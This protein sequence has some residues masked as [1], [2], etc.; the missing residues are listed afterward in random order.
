VEELV[1]AVGETGEVLGAGGR[2]G[3]GHSQAS[4]T[5]LS[6]CW[7]LRFSVPRTSHHTRSIETVA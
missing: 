3:E 6:I 1:A 5:F 2:A 4:I 7:H